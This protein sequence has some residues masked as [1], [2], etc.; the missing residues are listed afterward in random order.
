RGAA[1]GDGAVVALP[2]AARAGAG[3]AR[4]CSPVAAALDAVRACFRG[5]LPATRPRTSDRWLSRTHS[6]EPEAANHSIRRRGSDEDGTKRH[7]PVDRADHAG[8]VGPPD[9]GQHAPLI[10]HPLSKDHLGSYPSS[11]DGAEMIKLKRAYDA[12][13]RSDGYRVLVDRLWPRG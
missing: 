10:D 11:R 5:S 12:P 3:P 1:R 7:G 9:R 8:A 4:R 2:A 13:A 6:S